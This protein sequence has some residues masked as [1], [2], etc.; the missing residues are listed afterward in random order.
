MA[1]VQT[2]IPPVDGIG[3]VGA[4]VV[5][6]DERLSLVPQ[7][8]GEDVDQAGVAAANPV[9]APVAAREQFDCRARGPLR[10]EVVVGVGQRAV[11]Q[12][13]Q[14]ARGWGRDRFERE[15]H[16]DIGEIVPRLV[17][18]PNPIH[19]ERPAAE[20]LAEEVEHSVEIG[21]R[22]AHDLDAH[23]RLGSHRS[24][25]V[26]CG[27]RKD[28]LPQRQPGLVG[29]VEEFRCR[30]PTLHCRDPGRHRLRRVVRRQ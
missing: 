9:A 7:F 5:V 24:P 4:H 13:W 19:V 10:D 26:P 11:G 1:A 12:S 18:G 14:A 22:R 6:E 15:P 3:D 27:F 2:A 23:G 28:L 25:R 21:L 17:R 8:G 20:R 16:S 30:E 29:A